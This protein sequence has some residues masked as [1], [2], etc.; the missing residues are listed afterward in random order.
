M[1]CADLG[2]IVGAGSERLL[3]S[4]SFKSTILADG[5][6]PYHGTC[7]RICGKYVSHDTIAF[8]VS[9]RCV[10]LFRIMSF[11]ALSFRKCLSFPLQTLWKFSNSLCPSRNDAPKRPALSLSIYL[12][13]YIYISLS[14]WKQPLETKPTETTCGHCLWWASSYETFPWLSVQTLLSLCSTLNELPLKVLF[15][16]LH[17]LDPSMFDENEHSVKVST[18][19]VLYFSRN[20]EAPPF[21]V[22]R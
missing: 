17:S 1:L 21:Q 9:H 5:R 4:L 22:S 7:W 19:N 12:S 2:G 18:R 16:S 15:L 3:L 8:A 6:L 20:N 10:V 13:L 11:V 14:L